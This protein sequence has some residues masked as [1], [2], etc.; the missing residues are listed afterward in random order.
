VVGGPPEAF[1]TF[2]A[3]EAEKWGKVIQQANI[4]AQ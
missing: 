1:K 2:I 4:K 3:S